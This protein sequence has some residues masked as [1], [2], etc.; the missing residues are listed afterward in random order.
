MEIKAEIVQDERG[1]KYVRFNDGIEWSVLLA[2][3]YGATDNES[4]I[5]IVFDED[6]S[7]VTF[8]YGLSDTD[9]ISICCEKRISNADHFDG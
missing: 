2:F 7:I 9:I 6:G 8:G 1:R 4:D 3:E 5:D